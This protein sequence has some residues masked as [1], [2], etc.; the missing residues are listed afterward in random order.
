MEKWEVSLNKFLAPWRRKSC[1]AGA[2]LCGSYVTGNPSKHSDLDIH[3]VTKKGTDWRERGN[4]FVDGFLMEYLVNPP[5]QIRSYFKDDHRKF[6]QDA[7]IQ[8]KTGR[9]LFD[10]GTIKSLKEEANRWFAKKF[11]KF[12]RVATEIGKYSLWD[13]M[14][15]LEDC[16]DKGAPDFWFLYHTSLS[17][18]IEE[19]SKFMGYPAIKD[20]DYKILTDENTRRKYLLRD[21]PDS[22]FANIASKAILEKDKDDALAAYQKLT[23]HVFKGL[24]GF[25][26]DGWECRSPLDLK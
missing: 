15:D 1:V 8:F 20:K 24:G 14:D 5:E 11:K 21:F 22:E 3:I 7:V 6:Q 4:K 13:M 25:E 16:Y 17:S 19:Y 12:S 9:I 23:K 18:L 26:I 10:D 2:L